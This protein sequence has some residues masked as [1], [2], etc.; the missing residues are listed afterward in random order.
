MVGKTYLRYEYHTN[1]AVICSPQCNTMSLGSLHIAASSSSSSGSSGHHPSTL[2]F[3]PSLETVG[4]W[5]LESG[6][7]L[8]SVSPAACDMANATSL[9]ADSG[10][11]YQNLRVA[12]ATNEV[13]TMLVVQPKEGT[14]DT[15]WKLIVG[16]MNGYVA[17]FRGVPNR[18][19]ST[20]TVNP[21]VW[22]CDV[23][24]L[25]HKPD[26]QVLALATLG[27]HA[28]GNGATSE[29]IVVS[30]GQ[31]TDISVWDVT[32]QEPL[33]RLRGHRGGVVSVCFVPQRADIAN[34][35]SSAAEKS[36]LLG[37]SCG[38]VLVSGAADG[39]IKVWDLAV[40]QCIQT[41]VASDTQIT[42]MLF[43]L[44]SEEEMGARLS[45]W[46][47]RSTNAV[48]AND[49][50]EQASQN[51]A[52]AG[53]SFTPPV[54][55]G[56][57]YVGLRENIIKVFASPAIV[58]AVDADAK[59][60]GLDTALVPYGTIPR[61]THKAVTGMFMSPDGSL[62]GARSA[63]TV[64]VFTIADEDDLKRKLAQKRRRQA[65]KKKGAAAAEAGDDDTW[66]DAGTANLGGFVGGRDWGL[67]EVQLLK[68]FNFHASSMFGGGSDEK[69]GAAEESAAAAS[70]KR[71]LRAAAF[72]PKHAQ[73]TSAETSLRTIQL[74]VTY[75]DNSLETLS[76]EEREVEVS[77]GAS[78]AKILGDLRMVSSLTFSGHR[79]DIR[80]VD[81]VDNDE[82]MVTFSRDS[83]KLWNIAAA[84]QR[85]ASS[86]R[87]AKNGFSSDFDEYSSQ[88][89]ASQYRNHIL[90]E[91]YYNNVAP[92]LPSTLKVVSSVVPS[93]VV[94][95]TTSMSIKGASVTASAFTAVCCIASDVVCVGDDQGGLFLLNLKTSDVLYSDPHAHAGAV[96]SITRL[97][98]DAGFA[99]V[100]SDRRVVIWTLSMVQDAAEDDEHDDEQGGRK[101]AKRGRD[102][103][104]KPTKKQLPPRLVL[105]PSHEM[106][107]NETPLFL[108]YSH[109]TSGPT[110]SSYGRSS[111]TADNAPPPA[112]DLY[113][114]GLQDNNI[115]L[116]YADSNKPFLTLY[117]HKL[118]PT[119]VA[120]SS[121]GTL[122]A[123]VGLDKSLRFWGADF[124]DCHKAIHAHD[125]YI[126]RVQFVPS[127]HYVFT[128]SLD[129]SVKHWDGDNWTMIQMFRF[130]QR[131]LYG[132]AI[133]G[134][135]SYFASAGVDRCVRVA[136]R[137]EEMLFPEEEESRITQ[138]AMDAESARRAALQK[139]DEKGVEVGLPSTVT[140]ASA[141]AAETLMDALDL[142]SSEVQ[143]MGAASAS[144][145][146]PV[147]E[148]N[149]ALLLRNRSVWE[150]LWGVI[151]SIRPSELRHSLGS[152]TSIH[153][154][155]L[156]QYLAQMDAHGAILN[157]ETAAK[158]L[159]ALVAPPQGSSA[160]PI[161]HFEASS[162]T[163]NNGISAGLSRKAR[164]AQEAADALRRKQGEERLVASLSQLEALRT[165][166]SSRLHKQSDGLESNV[167]A[168]RFL[169]GAI[170]KR[171]QV[172]FF[173]LSKIQ[174]HKKQYHSRAFNE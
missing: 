68:C 42:S 81:F 107:L 58:A 80:S 149:T 86:G 115:Q 100:G 154:T 112:K 1:N 61:K 25:G 104:I 8:G 111:A 50:T 79:H 117:G 59:E 88:D 159:L 101:G 62:L 35:T 132:L 52:G 12:P 147:Q 168:L 47:N 67:E 160:R 46:N 14:D 44:A 60:A 33:Y 37:A 113:A 15:E 49:S 158:V 148:Q 163:S 171:D 165:S 39:M 87:A 36:S 32:A 4:V 85:I 135:G 71:R 89:L 16:Y 143:R 19:A 26:T 64:E 55:S 23:F 51:A 99:S 164:K 41:V 90:D 31:D 38:S 54:I 9:R 76:C 48:N 151:E 70:S 116:F 150:Y 120:F 5:A 66:G 122:V 98:Q 137:T 69:E 162:S 34:S 106:E 139:L 78:A 105:Q 7:L 29:Y 109:I 167:A 18:D 96:K 169:L 119:D 94:R 145:S 3:L 72:S 77:T 140:T 131:G 136:K 127:T 134:N 118:T 95:T 13:S 146:A 155:A 74:V 141:N 45:V 65:Q 92:P 73:S 2:A 133:S 130:H 153:L 123:S 20:N 57:L 53:D 110:F 144:G 82:A 173:D 152:L 166:I 83:I 161:L 125:D 124:G 157:Y 128:C 129:G 6:K 102:V 126:T 11:G 43:V 121:D 114:I 17:H 156:I 75:N 28:A 93:S 172:Q 30:G 84:Q 24:A 27:A 56:R 10:V 40:Q 103:D 91:C 138:E 142:V 174:G 97:P 170:E 21:L 63:D 22:S 108:R